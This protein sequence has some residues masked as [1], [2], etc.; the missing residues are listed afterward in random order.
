MFKMITITQ[1]LFSH[2]FSSSCKV[3]V[4]PLTGPTWLSSSVA[5][6]FTSSL[7]SACFQCI[8]MVTRLSVVVTVVTLP[9][10]LSQVLGAV[11]FVC[12]F[13][14]IWFFNDITAYAII[15]GICSGTYLFNFKACLL[16]LRGIYYWK[17]LGNS[18]FLASLGYAS[19]KWTKKFKWLPFSFSPP[20]KY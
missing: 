6:T 4:L 2:S 13:V 20:C 10:L 12:T 1:K 3:P 18:I 7:V 17:C 9:S 19:N 5:Q 8:V 16:Q 11:Q 14:L 15:Y